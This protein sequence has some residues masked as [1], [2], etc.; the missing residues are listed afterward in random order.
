[1]ILFDN[2]IIYQHIS[3]PIKYTNFARVSYLRA[4][5]Q[6]GERTR[7]EADGGAPTELYKWRKGKVGE[8]SWINSIKMKNRGFV[9]ELSVDLYTAKKLQ[10]LGRSQILAC[11]GRQGQGN[12]PGVKRYL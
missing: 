5:I 6:K 4:P 12:S 3:V 10:Y 11:K 2:I 8:M 7:E 9:S 1:M